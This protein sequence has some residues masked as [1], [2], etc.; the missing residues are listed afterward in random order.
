MTSNNILELLHDW[1]QPLQGASCRV[2]K[3]SLVE[4][5]SYLLELQSTQYLDFLLSAISIQGYSRDYSTIGI[6]W[7]NLPQ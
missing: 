4:Q 7:G 3:T 5:L 6:L 1:L 2:S